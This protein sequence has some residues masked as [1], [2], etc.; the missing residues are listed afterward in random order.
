MLR[1][2]FPDLHF[3]IEELVAKGTSWPGA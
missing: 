1:T 3:E 2:A